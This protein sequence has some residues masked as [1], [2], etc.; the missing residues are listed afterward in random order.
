MRHTGPWLR[1]GPAMARVCARALLTENKNT[2]TGGGVSGGGGNF[3]SR[4]KSVRD[5]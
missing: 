2:R 4:A 3:F 1:T 5:P